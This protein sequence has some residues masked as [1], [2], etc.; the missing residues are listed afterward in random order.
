[1][2]TSTL[3][4]I[5]TY[6]ALLAE[7][8]SIPLRGKKILKEAGELKLALKNKIKLTYILIYLAC[9]LLPLVVIFRNFSTLYNIMFCLV[10]VMGTEITSRD[11]CV[12]GHYGV[13]ENCLIAGGICVFYKDIVTFPILNF[14]EEEQEKYDHANLV[15]ATTSRGNLNMTFTSDDECSRATALVRE[16]SG[17]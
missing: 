11:A 17:K 16:L 6:A 9:L 1:M 10:S 2:T 15:I 7:F 8:C 5:L 13:Y 14:P 12:S 3:I 4:V